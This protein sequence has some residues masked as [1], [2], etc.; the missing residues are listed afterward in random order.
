MN[1]QTARP[2]AQF[3]PIS[4]SD[5]YARC[6]GCR[7][8]DRIFSEEFRRS[9][10]EEDYKPEARICKEIDNPAPPT[11]W[12]SLGIFRVKDLA[13]LEMYPDN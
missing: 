13:Y 8:C 1:N 9:L 4:A 7:S 5:A 11:D 12:V 3:L 10:D 6:F 2:E